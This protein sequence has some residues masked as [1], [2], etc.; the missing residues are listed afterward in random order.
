VKTLLN[1]QFA[2]ITGSI[3]FLQVGIDGVAD[4]ITEWRRRVSSSKK[5]SVAE[6]PDGFPAC[7]TSLEPLTGGL[8]PRELCVEVAE[9]WTAYVNCLYRGTD[10][11]STVGHLAQELTCQGLVI[12]TVPHRFGDPVVENG[13]MG[14]VQFQLF[15]PVRTDFLNYV[16]TISVSFDG[17]HWRFDAAGTPQPFEDPGAY[18]ARRIRER[19]TSDMLERYCRSLGIDVFNAETYGPRATLISTEM[20]PLPGGVVVSLRE[21]QERLGVIPGG[22]DRVPG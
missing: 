5:V 21:A 16:R 1:D 14:A 13:Q 20:P 8:V 4:A 19:F 2:P 6:L 18:T 3:G 11:I 22:A 12:T 15:G 17:D 9:G 7:L 10:A